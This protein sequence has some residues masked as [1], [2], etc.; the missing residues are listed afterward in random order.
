MSEPKLIDFPAEAHEA[1]ELEVMLAGCATEA[2]RKAVRE[3]FYTFAQ[4]DPGTFGVQ[5]AVLLAAH[6]RALKA[7]PE[8]LKKAVTGTFGEVNNTVAS[9]RVAVKQA[10]ATL[11]QEVATVG[12]QAAVANQDLRQLREEL[13]KCSGTLQDVFAGLV[14]ERKTIQAATGTIL[15]ISERRIIFGLL[16]AF[17]AGVVSCGAA[18]WIWT[19]LCAS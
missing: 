3:A 8:A 18:V 5:F 12:Q 9:H 14:E 10:Q 15:S 16:A 4:G 6:A 19:V 13:S 7:A 17:A 1:A 2:E 11:S